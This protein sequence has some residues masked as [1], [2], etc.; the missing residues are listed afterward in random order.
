MV[1]DVPKPITH[2]DETGGPLMKLKKERNGPEGSVLEWL[3]RL[4]CEKILLLQATGLYEPGMLFC[5]AA[6]LKHHDCVGAGIFRARF[7]AADP[8]GT[9]VATV[10]DSMEKVVIVEQEI[11][12]EKTMRIKDPSETFFLPY[13]TGLYAFSI[14]MLMQADL[15]DYAT[16]P[17]E[18]LPHIPRSPKI[19]YAATDLFALSKKPA[20]L[21][22][23]VNGLR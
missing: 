19:G 20:V 3:R 21:S 22:I 9:Y 8:F 5:L 16:P 1:D 17:K 6:A 10:K 13:N 2:P 23:P 15:P 4:G 12:N 7:D 14:D 11:R 18:I